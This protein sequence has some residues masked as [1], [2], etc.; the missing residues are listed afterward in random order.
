MDRRMANVKFNE[1]DRDLE[2]HIQ[3]LH[4]EHMSGAMDYEE[5]IR[6]RS[7]MTYKAEVQKAR[8][9]MQVSK[10]KPRDLAR[11]FKDK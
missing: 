1:I 4:D 10:A 3:L 7:L 8:V 6:R 11:V 2:H 9:E 5:F